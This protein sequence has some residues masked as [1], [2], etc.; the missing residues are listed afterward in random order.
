SITYRYQCPIYD[1]FSKF[2][3]RMKEKSPP[4]IREGFFAIREA[5]IR[6]CVDVQADVAEPRDL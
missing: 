1:T 5:A 6:G 3:F 2:I 4:E